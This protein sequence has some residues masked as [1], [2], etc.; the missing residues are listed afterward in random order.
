MKYGFYAPNFGA[1]GSAA[2][3]A[4]F[5]L[6]AEQAGWDG[7]FIWDHL[8]FPGIEPCVDPWVALAAMSVKTR[9]IK[10]GPLV[11][12]LPRRDL[13]KLARETVSIDHLSNGRLVFGV[14]LGFPVLPEWS[15]FGHE[16][17]KVIRGDM[18]DEGL[19]L[20]VQLWS[21]EPVDHT[22]THYSIHCDGFAPPVQ[23]PRIPVWVAGVWPTKRPFRRAARWDGV[24]PLPPN[25]M[26]GGT[27]APAEFAEVKTYI[28][29]L[30]DTAR[31]YDYIQYGTTT[32][33]ENAAD[34]ASYRDAGVTWW[35]EMGVTLTDLAPSPDGVLAR[36]R[37]GPPRN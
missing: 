15:G 21:G 32:G 20:L 35:M 1:F 16:D 13:A 24:V 23:K 17:D 36:I 3:L 10:L 34:T 11:T 37:R 25:L 14:G 6:E 9:T 33:P 18:L 8:Q 27:F 31:S 2:V 12:P 30:R 26:E 29:G 19:Q 28:D 22:G 5:A 7:F 4:D